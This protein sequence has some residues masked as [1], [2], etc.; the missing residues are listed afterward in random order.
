MPKYRKVQNNLIAV[1]IMCVAAAAYGS[2]YV[3]QHKGTQTVMALGSES[4]GYAQLIRNKVWLVG[5]ALFT[6]GFWLHLAAL[7][8]GSVAVVQPLIVLELIF[9]PPVAAIVSKTKVTGLEWLAILAVAGGLAGF[10]VVASPKAGVSDPSASQWVTVILGSLVLIAILTL[11]GSR[12][13]SIARAATLGVSAGIVNG[14]MA[15]TAK[16]MLDTPLSI[17]SLATNPLTYVTVVVALATFWSAAYAFKS[18]PI[19]VSSP[20]IIASNPI[21]ATIVSIWLFA[22]V[23]NSSPVALL[24]MALFFAVV[25]FGVVY[26]SK[27]ESRIEAGDV[28]LATEVPH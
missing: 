8:F 18:G 26:L 16:G 14:L 7:A 4:G 9:I 10:L 24:L 20:S 1:I 28:T 19:T 15:L 6:L 11:V 17:G 22:E 23:L 27:A 25:I 21:F 2:S 12:L 5:F 13:M 3:F